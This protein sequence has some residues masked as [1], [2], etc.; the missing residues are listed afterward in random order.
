MDVTPLKTQRQAL[1]TPFTCMAKQIDDEFEKE[2]P[3]TKQLSV[4]KA[5]L[6]DKL[7]RLE[8]CQSGI[9]VQIFKDENAEQV[10]EADFLSAEKYRDRYTE[11]CRKIDQLSLKETTKTVSPQRK[12]KLQKIELKKSLEFI[13]LD[14]VSS[15]LDRPHVTTQTRYL[16]TLKIE[17]RGNSDDEKWTLLCASTFL[18]IFSNGE[19]YRPLKFESTLIMEVYIQGGNLCEFLSAGERDDPCFIMYVLW[20]RKQRM[21]VLFTDQTSRRD[22]K[23]ILENDSVR[24]IIWIQKGSNTNS[25]TSEKGTDIEGEY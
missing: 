18:I 14:S 6:N 3:D 22:T 8:K 4:L 15:I 17:K 2:N 21:L 19:K 10:F 13:A 23:F 7:Q 5:Q 11:L 25:H 1:R 16:Y 12:F 9:S 24:S 20:T